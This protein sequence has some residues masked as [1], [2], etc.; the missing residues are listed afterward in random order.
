[1]SQT[2]RQHYVPKSYLKQ[3]GFPRKFGKDSENDLSVWTQR[4]DIPTFSPKIIEIGNGLC[5]EDYFYRINTK[6]SFLGSSFG[7][8]PNVIEDFGFLYEN[9]L[10]TLFKKLNHSGFLSGFSISKNDMETL[11]YGMVDIKWRNPW[12]RKK[13]NIDSTKTHQDKF[14]ENLPNFMSGVKEKLINQSELKENDIISEFTRLTPK[15]LYDLDNS[16]ASEMI[17][18]L[19]SS[20]FFRDGLIRKIY[21]KLITRFFNSRWSIIQT[22]TDNQFITSDNPGIFLN[23]LQVH[24]FTTI[25]QIEE[26]KFDRFFFPLSG[27][28]GLLIH[29]SVPDKIS[30][31]FEKKID[32]IY[33]PQSVAEYNICHC[34]HVNKI[35]IASNKQ[36][37][38]EAWKKGKD[39]WINK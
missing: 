35:L 17:K 26:L 28:H 10:P 5:A 24:S 22:N 7:N 34:V 14:K 20:S 38:K 23:K 25:E 16:S 39:S 12:V 30:T 37:L 6:N 32:I 36:A 31:L 2:K 9:E 11:A 8:N 19:H 27:L 1:M 13:Y 29:L 33:S 3:F 18:F 4:I 15:L 21:A